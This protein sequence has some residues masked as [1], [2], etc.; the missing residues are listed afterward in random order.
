MALI[1]IQNFKGSQKRNTYNKLLTQEIIIINECSIRSCMMFHD[2]FMIKD[3]QIAP[4][5]SHVSAL[6]M[7]VLSGDF[8]S[9]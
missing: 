8:F 1:S 2:N 7:I 9:K 4:Q 5:N 6:S 3:L